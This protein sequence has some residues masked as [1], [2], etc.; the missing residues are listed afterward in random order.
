MSSWA[1]ATG[2]PGNPSWPSLSFGDFSGSECSLPAHSLRIMA[3]LLCPDAIESMV[4]IGA[5]RAFVRKLRRRRV[6]TYFAYWRAVWARVDE[7][8]DGQRAT[9]SARLSKHI[10]RGLAAYH[11]IRLAMSG[12]AYRLGARVNPAASLERVA[13]LFGETFAGP[14]I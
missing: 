2:N 10:R 8:L 14:Q 1:T 4:M 13:L 7:H 3:R 6:A 5:N 11:M 9:E 12:A